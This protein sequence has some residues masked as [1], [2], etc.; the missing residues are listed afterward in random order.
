[1]RHGVGEVVDA[2]Q[3]L[4]SVTVTFST[5]ATAADLDGVRYTARACGLSGGATAPPW[6]PRTRA[7]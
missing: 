3:D 1:M 7:A 2:N 5:G 6:W 4:A